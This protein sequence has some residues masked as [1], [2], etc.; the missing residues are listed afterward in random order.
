[1]PPVVKCSLQRWWC[2]AQRTDAPLQEQPQTT[3]AARLQT[4]LAPTSIAEVRVLQG[5]VRCCEGGEGVTIPERRHGSTHRLLRLVEV[6]GEHAPATFMTP[7]HVIAATQ[8]FP[9]TIGAWLAMYMFPLASFATHASIG[10]S[11]AVA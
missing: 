3:P 8:P 9:T 4:A 2:S 7:V 11:G 6:P 1:M 5:R 10:P